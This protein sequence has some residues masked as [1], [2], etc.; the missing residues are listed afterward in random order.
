[1]T[2]IED[3]RKQFGVYNLTLN[4][5]IKAFD[6]PIYSRYY[7]KLPKNLGDFRDYQF[8]SEEFAEILFSLKDILIEFERDYYKWKTP[9]DISKTTGIEIHMIIS[10]LTNTNYFCK[11]KV[12]DLNKVVRDQEVFCKEIKRISDDTL[13][14]MISSYVIMRNIQIEMRLERIKS[15]L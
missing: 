6:I 11:A 7:S 10:H 4:N 2:T 3:I 5:F 15:Q 13:L 1:M 8:I 12:Q 9:V 14:K